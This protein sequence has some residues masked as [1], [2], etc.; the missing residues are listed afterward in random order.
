[1]V[2]L[3]R[4]VFFDEREIITPK[5]KKGVLGSGSY[6]TV[7]KCYHHAYRMVAVKVMQQDFRAA[8]S[9]VKRQ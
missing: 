7:Y 4:S 8:S 1:M 5:D 9:D 3:V 6:G 2:I